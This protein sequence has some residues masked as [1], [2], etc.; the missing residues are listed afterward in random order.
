MI[1]ND[2]ALTGKIINSVTVSA[3][4]V[5]DSTVVSDVSDDNDDTDGNVLDD[6]TEVLIILTPQIQVTKS[7]VV[8]QNNGNAIN[9]LG[10]TIVY[11]ITITNTGNVNLNNLT[12]TD[13][14][15]D[16]SGAGL[17]LTTTPTFLSGTNANAS[18][19]NIG[20]V[21]IFRATFTINQQ[22][23]DTGGVSN[24]AFVTA[25]STVDASKVASDTSDDPNTAAADDK[26][27]ISITATP[28]IQITKLAAVSDPDSNGIDIGDT[29]TYTIVATNTG[30]LTLS[31]IKLTDTLTDANSTSLS[32]SSGPT[33]TS[34]SSSSLAV[35]G[36]ITYQATFCLLY[37]S[38]SPRD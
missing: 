26:T 36:A 24:V 17:T 22:A 1:S 30:D 19:I 23:V 15:T 16:F 12:V 31:N 2:A 14:L 21:A 34:G 28:S 27:A 25:A 9:D 10:D 35:G 32:L 20:C 4:S 18:S 33:I 7:A 13:T 38:P 8:T 6:P 5:S 37:T 3:T 29:I 11:T